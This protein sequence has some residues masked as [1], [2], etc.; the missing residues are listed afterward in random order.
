MRPGWIKGMEEAGVK[1]D[2]VPVFE[3]S[4]YSPE[5]LAERYSKYMEE[6]VEVR[7]FSSMLLLFIL[8]RFCC[9]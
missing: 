7:V 4:D 8:F 5:R 3:E 6:S 1:R 9:S 2:W